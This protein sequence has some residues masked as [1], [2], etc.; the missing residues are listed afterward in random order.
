MKKK[1]IFLLLALGVLL[2]KAN[3]TDSESNFKSPYS[4]GVIPALA[5]D[6]DLGLK[7]GAVFNLFDYDN[8]DIH[9]QY[10]QYLYAKIINSTGG[11]L[12]LQALLE[13]D[14]LIKGAKIFAEASYIR[15]SQLD[16]YG[17][18]GSNALY[19]PK[20]SDASHP[21]FVSNHFYSKQR[22]MTRLR[23]DIQTYLS[24]KHFRLLTGYTFQNFEL[25]PDK[26]EYQSLADY[27]ISTGSLFELYKT[28]NII[29]PAERNGGQL[30]LFTAGLVYDL[31][32]EFCYCTDG[33]WA[34]TFLIYSPGFGA[35]NTFS[36]HVATLRQHMSLPG[37]TFTFSYRI[38]SQQ[39]LSGRIPFYMLP[40]FFDTRLTN[41]G[42]AGAFG[43]RGASRNSIV[44]DGFLSSNFEAK[45][46]FVDTKIRNHEF[47]ASAV[48]FYD[49]SF[50]TQPY[51][52]STQDI[53]AM[54]K[55]LL[56]SNNPQKLHHTYGAGLYIVFNKNNI[57]TINYG[58][59][60]DPQNGNGGLYIG[61]ALLF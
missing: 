20:L 14:K 21:A 53:P 26:G 25:R 22:A 39:K 27:N 5:Y 59:S 16:F 35:G 18:N 17:F 56:F 12:Q 43:L 50:I 28:W 7:Y 41:D 51:R 42:P 44:G 47:Y 58:I 36:K 34:E 46:K 2:A 40:W 61:S 4:W 24:N 48:V 55:E 1:S 57:I 60:P 32:N 38:S 29:D 13:S 10:H 31:R 33:I 15:D 23:F 6:A 9:P 49:N 11:T 19:H 52:Y 37:E 45:L 54:A 3:Q 8:Y 30:H